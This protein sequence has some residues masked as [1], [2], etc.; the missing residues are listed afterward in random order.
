MPPTATTLTLPSDK[1]QVP[2]VGC[3]AGL[4][5]ML[6]IACEG[7]SI[8]PA[9]LHAELREGGDLPDLVSGAL[10]PQA[11]RLT[12]RALALMRY[13]HAA[14]NVSTEEQGANRC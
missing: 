6:E 2:P 13:P 1:E 7:L 9:Q 3:H 4:E 14:S 12:A 5:R 11:L 10:T 8:T